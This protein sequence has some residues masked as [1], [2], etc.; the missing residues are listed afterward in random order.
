LL[1]LKPTKTRAVVTV[2]AGQE[3]RDLLFLSR[4]WMERYVAR[5]DAEFVVLD[6]EMPEHGIYSKFQLYRVLDHYERVV[7]LDADAW[8]DPDHCP[9]LFARVP[10]GDFG[11]YDDRPGLLAKTAFGPFTQ[12]NGAVRTSQGM[13]VASPKFYG[14]TGVMVFDRSH[15]DI[16]A[17]PSQPIPVKHCGEQTL[18]VARL[19][20]SGKPITFLSDDCNRQWWEHGEFERPQ[21][22]TAILHFSGMRPHRSPENRIKEM[23][24]VATANKWPIPWKPYLLCA[25]GRSG[26]TLLACALEDAGLGDPYEKLSQD[27]RDETGLSWA[28]SIEA[29]RRD[30][31]AKLQWLQMVNSGLA[32]KPPIIPDARYVSVT[33]RD[34]IRQAVSRARAIQTRQ[35]I[36]TQPAHAE[37]VY[38]RA[39]ISQSLHD[40]ATFQAGWEDYFRS[41]GINPLRIAYED[42]D[43]NYEATVRRV[44][45]YLGEGDREVH[46]PRIKRQADALTEEWVRRFLAGE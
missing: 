45:D 5:L 18:W 24:R 14:N 20:D 32:K 3:G 8:A 38:D 36:A 27:A 34:M 40:L 29:I 31:C 39:A 11:I 33:R 12:E 2:A 19:Q 15:R 9:D 46:P 37:P 13:P 25:I 35:W 6:W 41:H 10:A 22:P 30:G 43:R 16:L 28:E 1:D 42:L 26:S 4:P 23:R 44:L 21:P 7:F 17:P